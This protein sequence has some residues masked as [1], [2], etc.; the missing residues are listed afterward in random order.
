VQATSTS[1]VCVSLNPTPIALAGRTDKT[2][3]DKDM[4]AGELAGC[5]KQAARTFSLIPSI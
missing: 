5:R 3:V 1:P 4:S 2:A